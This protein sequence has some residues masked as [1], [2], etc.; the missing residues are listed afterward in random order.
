MKKVIEYTIISGQVPLDF[1]NTINDLIKD[2][3][4]PIGGI[5]MTQ[6]PPYKDGNFTVTETRCYQAMV[7]YEN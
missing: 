3:W 7:K 1:I 6:S 4:Q 5:C 2:G